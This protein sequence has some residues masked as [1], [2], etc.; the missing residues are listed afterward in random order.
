MIRYA[1]TIA[2]GLCACA[3]TMVAGAGPRVAGPTVVELYQSQGCSSC[4]PADLVLN[5]IADRPDV[6]AL[7]FAVTYWDDLGWKDSFAKPAFT[8][9]QWDYAHAGGRAQ[10]ATPQ[11]IVDGHGVLTGNTL[12]SAQDAIARFGR[13]I[14]AVALTVTGDRATVGKGAAPGST[15][16]L[17]AY[18]PRTIDVAV[19][20]GENSGRTIPHRNIVRALT[21]L[22]Q[23]PA[24]GA[25]FTRPAPAPG[26][27]RALLVQ[28]GA[29][30]PI[31][32]ARAI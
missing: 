17:V 10:V 12:A 4:P 15:L 18:D 9:R 22:G 16:W 5:R 27:R 6:L 30:G 13:R 29:G 32:A 31:L 7:N 26:Y 14:D 3:A 25:S 28:N 24:A 20:A 8:R 21:A 2:M 11:M 1:R 23:V 19:G